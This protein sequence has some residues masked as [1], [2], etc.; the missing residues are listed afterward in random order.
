M[1]RLVAVL[2]CGWSTGAWAAPPAPA[3]EAIAIPGGESGVGYDDLQYA[4]RSK[5]ILV[6]AG[7]TGKLVLIDP[8]TNQV[9]A[10][11]GF[12]SSAGYRGGHGEGT[13]SAA[14]LEEPGFVVA[15]DRGAKALRIVDTKAGTASKPVKLAASPDYVRV[16]APAHEVWVSEPSSKQLEVL[17][18]EGSPPRLSH[19]ANIPVPDGPESLVIDAARGRAY[20]HTWAT[21]SFAIDLKTRK[22]VARWPNGCRGSR[23]IAL[24]QARG[25]LFAGC[26][27]GQVTVVELA[28]GKL[29]ASA[30][31]GPEVDSIGYAAS[32][33]HLYVPSGRSAE[34]SVFEVAS[35]GKLTL[36]GKLPTAPDAHT[37]TFDPDSSAVFVGTPA[38]GAVWR[39]LDSFSVR[40]QIR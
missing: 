2:F 30:A 25:L 9:T 19:V 17:R 13:T 26:A 21:E 3:A 39:H 16:V 5:R 11:G 1:K 15:T 4:P 24:D 28:T 37:V 34:L 29:V 10:I 14:E 27:E 40:S 7:R 22:I 35:D 6:P 20:S 18:V 33:G 23:G 12:S 36:L 32:L 38:H 31:T 8:A